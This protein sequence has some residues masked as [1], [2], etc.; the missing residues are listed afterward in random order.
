MHIIGLIIAIA[1]AVFWIG[2]AARGAQDV[3]D[4]AKGVSNM[5]RR[6][7]FRKKAGKRGIDLIDD[8]TEAATILMVCVAKLSRYSLTNGGLIS[9][10]AT[11]KIIGIIQSYMKLSVREAEEMFTQMHWSVQDLVQPETALPPMT[12][13]LRDKINHAEAEDLSDM[14]RKVSLADGNANDGQRAF[15]DKFRERTGLGV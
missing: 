12:N 1:T 8:P 4:F 6:N 5:P 13:I 9:A 15:I 3:A 7:R 10:E 11:S 14:M 2:R